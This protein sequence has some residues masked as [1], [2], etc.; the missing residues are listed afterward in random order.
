[1]LWSGLVNWKACVVGQECQGAFLGH[2]GRPELLDPK[3][4]DF[5]T[6]KDILQPSEQGLAAQTWGPG[7]M[8][9]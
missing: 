5:P 1:M 7:G 9:S 2:W 6:A 8:A 4:A 3:A